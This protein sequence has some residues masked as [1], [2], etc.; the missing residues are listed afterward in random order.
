MIKR[1]RHLVTK[2]KNKNDKK[3]AGV[4]IIGRKWVR[5]NDKRSH[6]NFNANTS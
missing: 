3:K 6:S 2:E 1:E 5:N 4:M